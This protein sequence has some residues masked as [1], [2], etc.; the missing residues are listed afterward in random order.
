MVW[1]GAEKTESVAMKACLATID[2]LQILRN[3]I[4]FLYSGFCQLTLGIT[5]TCYWIALGSSPADLDWGNSP[6]WTRRRIGGGS[7]SDMERQHRKDAEGLSD[8]GRKH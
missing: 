6:C 3:K 7:G 4:S 1:N 8:E 5:F 2:I